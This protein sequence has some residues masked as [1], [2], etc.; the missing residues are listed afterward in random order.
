MEHNSSDRANIAFLGL[1]VMGGPMAAHLARAGH[2]VT[3]YNRTG[4]KAAGWRSALA[5]EGVE[6]RTAATPI[7][8]ARDAGWADRDI[9]DAVLQ[10]ASNRA[11][12]FVL[13]AF[14]VETQDAFV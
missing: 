13:K 4:E 5:A 8:A 2:R 12:N 7:D 10:A 14:N 9:F 6:A 3:A 11:F 1:G